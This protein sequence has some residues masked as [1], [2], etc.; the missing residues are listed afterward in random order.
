MTGMRFGLL[1]VLREDGYIQAGKQKLSAWICECDCGKITRVAGAR[2]RSGN[3]KSCGC[4]VGKAAQAKRENLTGQ[5]FGRLTVISYAG[6]TKDNRNQWH[7]KC[8]C[9]N[10]TVV[11]TCNLKSGRTK[12]CGCLHS[13]ITS[14]IKKFTVNPIQDFIEFGLQ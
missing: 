6:K 12:S 13:E 4:L 1:T 14:K 11:K 7:C 8:D 9:G 5:R 10:T 2:L 3:T